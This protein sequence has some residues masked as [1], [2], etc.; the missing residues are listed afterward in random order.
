MVS[1][2]SVSRLVFLI[3][4]RSWPWAWTRLHLAASSPADGA[5]ATTV[6]PIRSPLD[7]AARVMPATCEAILAV[8]VSRV[9]R[10]PA[11][12]FRTRGHAGDTDHRGETRMRR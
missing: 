5:R 3:M 6:P 1:A 9:R 8:R 2:V 12:L 4:F 7:Q 10:Q 11:S